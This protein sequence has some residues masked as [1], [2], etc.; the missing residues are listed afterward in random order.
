M[1]ADDVSDL[2]GFYGIKNVIHTG[3]QKLDGYDKIYTRYDVRVQ[4]SSAVA[5]FRKLFNF[6]HGEKQKKLNDMNLETVQNLFVRDNLHKI[7]SIE[8]T[9]I[10]EDVWDVTVDDVTHAF[11][12]NTVVTGNCSEQTLESYELCCLCEVYPDKHKSKEDFMR[13]LKFAYL[14]AKSVTLGD[15]HWVETNRVMKRNR[16][17]GCSVTGLVQFIASRGLHELKTWLTEGYDTI[18]YWD[19]VYSEYLTIPRSVKTT[20]VK[21][22]GCVTLDTKVFVAKKGEP[23][24]SISMHDLFDHC[25]VKYDDEQQSIWHDVSSYGLTTTSHTGETQPINKLFINGRSECYEIPL[26][27]GSTITCTAEHKFLVKRDNADTWVRCDEL[28]DGDEFVEV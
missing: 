20:S 4:I 24:Q 17:I 14:Y 6:T 11:E 9:D 23:E 12:L 25:E 27:N 21:P 28:K 2:L 1:L 16:R 15:S 13:T 7:T 22:S 10:H 19:Q 26:D 18:Q 8:L 5:H 3:T